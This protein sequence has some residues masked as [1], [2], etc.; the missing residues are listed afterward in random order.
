MERPK[1]RSALVAAGHR[2]ARGAGVR[3]AAGA[4]GVTGDGA[5]GGGHLHGVGA[6]AGATFITG[7]GAGGGG[8]F[9]GVGAGGGT[10]AGAGFVTRDGTGGRS[11]AGAAA[12]AVA[13]G[14]AHGRVVIV[15]LVVVADCQVLKCKY[16]LFLIL[17]PDN[18]IIS[19]DCREG[20]IAPNFSRE[21]SRTPYHHLQDSRVDTSERRVCC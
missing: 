14:G 11:T 20:F 8:H 19:E 1:G 13:A 21:E 15:G 6:A 18:N 2:A 16:C 12:A 17:V 5:G 9:H 7:D 3:A 4:A 10:A